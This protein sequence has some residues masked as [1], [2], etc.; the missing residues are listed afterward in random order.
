MKTLVIILILLIGCGANSPRIHQDKSPTS[1]FD[2]YIPDSTFFK[3]KRLDRT[4]DV[5]ELDVFNSLKPINQ[6]ESDAWIKPIYGE[7]YKVSGEI[8]M[9]AFQKMTDQ[10]YAFLVVRIFDIGVN[11]KDHEYVIC[12]Q[13]L[14]TT[15]K[16]GKY[17]SSLKVFDNNRVDDRDEDNPEM[18]FDKGRNAYRTYDDIHS[19]FLKKSIKLFETIG[20]CKNL[21]SSKKD[22]YWEDNFVSQYVISDNGDIYCNKQRVKVND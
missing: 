1:I 6:E 14:I 15:N 5:N 12:D 11:I 8:K 16:Q 20:F 13:F 10:Y 4:L 3:F 22:D 17:I 19:E 9:V 7:Q 18:D 21:N 2:S